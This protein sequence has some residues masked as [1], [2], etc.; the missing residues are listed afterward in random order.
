MHCKTARNTVWLRTI[1]FSYN[2]FGDIYDGS[3]AD[4]N[5][6]YGDYHN[7][8]VCGRYHGLYVGTINCNPLAMSKRLFLE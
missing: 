1:V 6:D 7:F 2:D 5:N 3:N 4:D 8:T